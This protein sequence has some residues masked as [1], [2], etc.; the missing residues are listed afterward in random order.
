MMTEK[1]PM[2]EVDLSKNCCI[3]HERLSAFFD[4]EEIL[5]IN[6]QAHMQ[7]CNEC[8]DKLG[9]FK[10][11]N[12]CIN[13]ALDKACPDDITERVMKGVKEKLRIHEGIDYDYEKQKSIHR[14]T[15]A[16][17]WFARVAALVA[18]A[19]LLSYF[20]FMSGNR[21][22]GTDIASNKRTG[23]GIPAELAGNNDFGSVKYSDVSK[24]SFVGSGTVQETE[25]PAK[26]DSSV[27]HVWITKLQEADTALKL[28]EMLALDG[29]KN[30]SVSVKQEKGVV[31]VS[32]EMTARQTAQFVRMCRSAGCS[33]L[34]PQQPQPEQ[35]HFTG[36]GT[37]PVFYEAQFVLPSNK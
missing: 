32:G 16:S 7:V 34:S 31:T 17:M 30:D 4:G 15:D 28:R 21:R 27:K 25:S 18:F 23:T 29:V 24:I 36:T 3:S 22:T 5:S 37:E 11:I 10:H 35:S 19:C 1:T 14:R 6:E 12:S 9:H 20:V 33:L 13:T 2:P 8:R 26:I